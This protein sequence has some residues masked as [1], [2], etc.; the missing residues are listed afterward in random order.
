MPGRRRFVSLLAPFALLAACANPPPAASLP[1]VPVAPA[2]DGAAPLLRAGDLLVLGE[3][4]G[5]EEFPSLIGDL[6]AEAAQRGPVTVHLELLQSEQA[7][8]DGLVTGSV[9]D[10]PPR[11][12]P[13]VKPGQYGVTSA[14]MWKLLL[15]LAA[16][17]RESHRVRI[18]LFDPGSPGQ[19]DLADARARDKGM[20]AAV[21]RDVHEH[22]GDVHVALVGNVH[23]RQS[24]GVPWD[25]D[26]DPFARLVAQ[27]GVRTTSLLGTY[28]AGSLWTCEAPEPSSC[29]AHP[30]AGNAREISPSRRLAL[31][32]PP[33][34]GGYTG[35]AFVG[36][37]H[38]SRP[39]SESIASGP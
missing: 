2:I 37:V 28:T 18:H 17:S 39:A 11:D 5:S 38:V 14:A 19:P 30:F 7:R 33:G 20:A 24:H 21:A 15:R 27:A 6:A 23:A 13:W 12:G 31:G 22:L 25:P 36:A 3:M 16:I 32:A 1:P 34:D 9:P 29:G 8:I 4:H 10:S 35:T 26:Y